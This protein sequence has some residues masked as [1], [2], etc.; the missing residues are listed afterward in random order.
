M[1]GELPGLE[2]VGDPAGALADAAV[3]VTGPGGETALIHATAYS[4]DHQVMAFLGRQIERRGGRPLLCSPDQ[5][6]WRDGRA[7]VTGNGHAPVGLLLRFFPAEWLPNLPRASGWRLHFAEG[8]TPSSNPGTALLTQSKRFPLVW[9]ELRT[10]VPTWRALLPETRDP[11]DVKRCD[12]SWVLKPALG[13]VGEGIGLHGTTTTADWRK[14]RRSVRWW[15]G[16]WAAQRRFTVR[17]LDTPDGPA[18]ACLGVYVV[19]GRACGVYGRMARSAVIDAFARDV[20]VLRPHVA[21]ASGEGGGKEG[22]A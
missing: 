3:R 5:L 20:A 19:D 7:H 8:R 21:P 13:R 11:R 1:A 15:P 9:D 2:P 22:R 10:P 16:Y 6:A 4:D 14:I 18:Q 17:P 12:E